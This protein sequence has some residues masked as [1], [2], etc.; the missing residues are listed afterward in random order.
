M[1]P[2]M[3][4]DFDWGDVQASTPIH[5]KGDYELTIKRLRG[6]AWVKKDKQGNPTSDITE[7]IKLTPE[8]VGKYNS[9][10]SLD[11]SVAGQAAEEI[12][13]WIHSEGG[14]R[15]SK[16][17]MMAI[18]GYNPQDEQE[19]K[20][21]NQFMKDSKLDL[22]AKV[23]E[24]QDGKMTLTI[25]E[26]WAKLLVGKNVRA[27]MEPEVRAVEGKED[28]TQQKYSRLSPVNASGAKASASTAK[29]PGRGRGA[30]AGV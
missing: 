1:S 8:L 2:R 12:S 6:Q 9:D 17:Q 14:R 29:A 25:G 5:P 16:Q 27:A 13:L 18:A 3:E 23:E 4:A 10:G 28:V 11:T 26:G 15:M 7:V 21:F 30:P 19:E 24:D 22:S 20:K